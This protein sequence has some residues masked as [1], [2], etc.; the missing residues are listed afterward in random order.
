MF[1]PM[2][3]LTGIL[4]KMEK[5]NII[6]RNR[7]AEDRRSVFVSLNPDFEKNSGEFLNG[8]SKMMNEIKEEISEE[9]FKEFYDTLLDIETIL[10]KRAGKVN[11]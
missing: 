2:S 11:E 4:D 9:V 5:K 3:T 10:K 8:V 1:M 6:I 7:C